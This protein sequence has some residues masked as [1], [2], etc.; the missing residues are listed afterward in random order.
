MMGTRACLLFGLWP[1]R[2]S[3]CAFLV[4]LL[5]IYESV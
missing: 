1:V 2:L 5:P 3:S 4:L